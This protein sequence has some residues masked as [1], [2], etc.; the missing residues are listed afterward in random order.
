MQ[1]KAGV[2]DAFGDAFL[3]ECAKALDRVMVKVSL[4]CLLNRLPDLLKT[5]HLAMRVVP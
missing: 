4:K 3:S 5:N 1:V 2:K